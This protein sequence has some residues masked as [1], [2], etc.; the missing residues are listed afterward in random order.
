MLRMQ[1]TY[2]FS[3]PPHLSAPRPSRTPVESVRIAPLWLSCPIG[4]PPGLESPNEIHAIGFSPRWANLDDRWWAK[5]E[6]RNHPLPA[7]RSQRRD[8]KGQPCGRHAIGSRVAARI[9]PKG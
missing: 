2:A 4:S 9:L 6:Y 3:P 8:D 1:N 7:V 5:L